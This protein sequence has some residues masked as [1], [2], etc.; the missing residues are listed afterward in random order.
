[1]HEGLVSSLYDVG[2]H[3]E[4][5]KKLHKLKY[6]STSFTTQGLLD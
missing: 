5:K 6:K 4:R 1:M 2:L 3:T